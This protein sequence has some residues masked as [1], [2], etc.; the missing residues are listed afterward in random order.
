MFTYLKEKMKTEMQLRGFSEKTQKS[1][2]K[3]V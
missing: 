3:Y 2:I 1:Y